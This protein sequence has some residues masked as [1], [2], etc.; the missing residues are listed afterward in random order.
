[1]AAIAGIMGTK[2][3]HRE[4][5]VALIC[6]IFLLNNDLDLVNCPDTSLSKCANDI[7]MQVIVKK[8]I[9]I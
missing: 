7:T 9:Q 5:L 6:L 1:M 2:A 4:A 3:Q 8:A